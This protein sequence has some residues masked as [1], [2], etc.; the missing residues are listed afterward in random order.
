LLQQ[1]RGQHVVVV[2]GCLPGE[3][4]FNRIINI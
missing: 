4:T 1:I 3:C 2:V